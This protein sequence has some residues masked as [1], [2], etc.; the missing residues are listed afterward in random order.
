MIEW[1]VEGDGRAA[2]DCG[3]RSDSEDW[4]ILLVVKSFAILHLRY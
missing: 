1:A 4:A 2:G 3:V